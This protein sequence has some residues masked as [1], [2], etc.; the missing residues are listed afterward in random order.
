MRGLSIE[1]KVGTVVILAIIILLYG[2]IWVKEYKFHVEHYEYSCLFP[3]VGTLDIGD[4][5]SVLGVDKG[6]VKDIKLAGNNVLVRFSISTDVKLKEDAKFKVMNVGLMGERF[7][8]IWPGNSEKD[9]NLDIPAMGKYDT[10]IPE[11]MG[12]MGEGIEEIRNLVVQI[13]G[14]IG[15]TGKGEEVRQIIDRL[16]HITERISWFVDENQ[17]DMDGAM[18]DLG[19]VASRMRDFVDSNTVQMQAV[20]DNFE[21]ASN[22]VNTVITTLDELSQDLHDLTRRVS[23]GEGTLGKAIA[24]DSLYLDLRRALTNFD[25]LVTDFKAHP[26][27]YIH[28]SIF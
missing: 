4:P 7:V 17:A 14:T 22:K 25:S 8:A 26:K 27:K 19:F 12:M 10:G 24:D 28:L 3:Q 2:V 1:V 16:D 13:E 5:V 23:Q 18:K 9:L 15:K 6:E 11:V 21:G 20:V